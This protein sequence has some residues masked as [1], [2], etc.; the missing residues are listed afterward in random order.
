MKINK[1]N[2]LIWSITLI[3]CGDTF[4]QFKYQAQLPDY[5]EE[6]SGLCHSPEGLWTV[7]DG[8]NGNFIYL[9]PETHFQKWVSTGSFDYKAIRTYRLPIANVDWEAIS[10]DSIFLYI[11]DFGN[12]RGNRKDLCIYKIR[13]TELL[14]LSMPTQMNRSSENPSPSSKQNTPVFDFLHLDLIEK[15]EF[16]YHDQNKFKE[17][18]LH[19]FDCES[20]L[21][22]NDQIILLSKNWKNLQS[23]AYSIPNKKG[24]HRTSTLGKL[25]PGF[26]I[27]DATWG[28]DGIYVCGYGPSGFQHVAKID[29][30]K[31]N[32]TERKPLLI[33][34]AQ[35]EGIYYDPKVKRLILSTEQR[36]TQPATL[37]MADWVAQ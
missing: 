2:T 6:T 18:K 8:G 23:T 20:M 24:K 14:Q 16:E 32:I 36:K 1:I 29:T 10:T 35:F 28:K 5:L 9:Y 21:I 3:I 7:N 37:F 4:G 17:R 15:I 34:P 12:N 30:K 19:N 25:N 26:L 31:W 27:T 13:L 22:Q 33:Q 11:G